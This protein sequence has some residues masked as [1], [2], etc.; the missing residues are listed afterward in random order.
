MSY[1]AGSILI[2]NEG[3]EHEAFKS[4]ANLMNRELLFTFYSFDMERVNVLFHVFMTFMRDK[5][6][7][8]HASFKKSNISC[9]IFLFEW[10]V[11]L[12]SNIFPLDISAR[13]WD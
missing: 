11:A 5:L 4:F 2:H 10:I 13:L 7:K 12:Y 8:L 9:S 3:K 6:P 1:V